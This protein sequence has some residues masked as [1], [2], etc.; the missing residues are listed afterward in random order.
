M[1]RT[2]AAVHP[3]KLLENLIKPYTPP[4]LDGKKKIRLS[5]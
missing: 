2:T 5:D 1:V 4:H 3:G